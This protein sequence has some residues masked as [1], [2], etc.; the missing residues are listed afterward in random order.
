MAL[1]PDRDTTP[2]W[3]RSSYC[4][5]AN[6]MEVTAL[7]GENIAVRDSKESGGP[8]L[9]FTRQEFVAFLSGAK[10]GDFDHLV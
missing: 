6:C 2:S 4:Q 3:L 1:D 8:I 5:S 10:S 9:T 7:D